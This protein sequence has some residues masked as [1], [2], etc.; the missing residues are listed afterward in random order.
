MFRILR[1]SKVHCLTGPYPELVQ[2]I[3]HFHDI[4]TLLSKPKWTT[5]SPD[6]RFEYTDSATSSTLATLSAQ[7]TTRPIQ[8]LRSCWGPTNSPARNV[9]ARTYY[10]RIK[11]VLRFLCGISRVQIEVRRPSYQDLTR[12]VVV[13]QGMCRDSTKSGHDRFLPYSVQLMIPL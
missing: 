7:T 10:S 11:A 4:L 13:P 6:F 12:F 5:R 9:E 8:Q 1:N 2:S 3:L